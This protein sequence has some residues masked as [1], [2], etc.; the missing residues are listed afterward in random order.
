MSAF[1]V[2]VAIA[3][4]AAISVQSSLSG[5]IGRRVGILETAFMLHLAGLVLATFL[6]LV[7]GSG[8]VS[9][10]RTV[11]WY[12]VAAGFLGVGIVAAVSY[13]VPRLGLATA[14]TL[15]IVAQLFLGAFLDQVGWLGAATRPLD[16]T[17]ILGMFILLVG[18][19]LVVR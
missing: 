7:L 16:A 9:S 18:T 5:F 17:R 14:L 10:W 4:G 3:A 15:T 6:L 12:A 19:W 11:P 13:T 1:A 8:T 2:F